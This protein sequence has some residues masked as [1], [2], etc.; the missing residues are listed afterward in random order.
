MYL[1]FMD[2]YSGLTML[3]FLKYKS[4]TLLATRKH[5]ADIAPYSHVK[6]LWTDN[7]TEFSSKPISTVTCTKQNQTQSV[8]SFFYALKWNR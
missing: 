7:G 1:I 4:D 8:R 5:L 6:C 3:Y 2:D